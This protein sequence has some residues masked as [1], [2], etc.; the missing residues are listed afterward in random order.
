M[1]RTIK[2]HDNL[3]VKEY[4][5][6]LKR[7]NR[8]TDCSWFWREEH[9]Q[10]DRFENFELQ[11]LREKRGGIVYRHADDEKGISR[12]KFTLTQTRLADHRRERR[13]RQAVWISNDSAHDL[14][15]MLIDID[16]K[17]PEA[18]VEG[19]AAY[20]VE[21]YLGGRGYV[22][23]STGGD[24]RHVY[25]FVDLKFVRRAQFNK[26][27][28]LWH[29]RMAEDVEF[30][31]RY[32]VTFDPVPVYGIPTIWD[33]GVLK[34]RGNQL[35]VPYLP[36]GR[37]D[38][39]LLVAQASNPVSGAELVAWADRQ[40]AK[41]TCAV[42]ASGNGIPAGEYTSGDIHAFTHRAGTDTEDQTHSPKISPL[43]PSPFQNR[44][45]APRQEP[46]FQRSIEGFGP[47]RRLALFR[48][49][50]RNNTRLT[51]NEFVA[52]Y[53][54]LTPENG[55]DKKV[56]A[57][58]RAME[59]GY[60]HA[61][62]KNSNTRPIDGNKYIDVVT[63]AVP[64]L[65]LVTEKGRTNLTHE[66]VAQFVA[67]KMHDAANVGEHQAASDRNTFIKFWA[68]LKN[69]GVVDW[70]LTNN[71]HA[72]LIKLCERYELLQII[73][74]YTA[75]TAPGAKNGRCRRIGPGRALADEYERFEFTRRRLQGEAR[76][77]ADDIA[78]IAPSR[79]L[80]RV[81]Q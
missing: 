21:K 24:G 17:R 78:L 80:N 73:E 62:N 22:E 7:F 12:S 45:V 60:V 59:K 51:E 43:S 25:F 44:R 69:E 28:K 68:V 64:P 55:G 23:I 46:H 27:L 6:W 49:M 1:G 4:F 2:S 71:A 81:V 19:A 70:M 48:Q 26:A 63:R 42:A 8:L 77:L 38:F 31:K 34:H 5:E 47:E 65:A 18:D 50:K 57:D 75:P 56:R 79:F 11:L 72:T 33:D 14:V 37:A 76:R 52:A 20:I 40:K 39:E 53:N 16:L 58:F 9:K 41:G 10:R 15:L 36:R 67:V 74:D 13:K 30:A 61:L 66:R 35:K 3:P 54:I 32:K 29:Q